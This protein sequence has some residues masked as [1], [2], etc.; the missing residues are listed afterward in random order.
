MGAPGV[1]AGAA[2]LDGALVLPGA[3]AGDLVVDAVDVQAD[4]DVHGVLELDVQGVALVE[5]DQRA[6]D[7]RLAPLEAVAHPPAGQA[8]GV[9]LDPAY[10]APGGRGSRRGG[11]ARG[12]GCGGQRCRRHRGAAQDYPSV[13]TASVHAELPMWLS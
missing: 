12:L 13:E 2:G 8:L 6:G 3:V 10:L 7:G 1:D 4:R 9:H 11:G 5:L